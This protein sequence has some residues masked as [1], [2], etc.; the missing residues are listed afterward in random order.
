MRERDIPGVVIGVARGAE[1]PEYLAVGADAAGRSLADDTLFP[2]TSITKLATALAVLR[3]VAAG[4]LALNDPLARHLPE[5]AAAQEGVTLRTI[6][7]HT[8]GLPDDLAPDAAPYTADLNWPALAQA[9]LATSLVESPGT[10]VRYSSVGFGL[11]AIIVERLTGR[12][13]AAALAE[14]VLAPLGVEGYLGDEPPWTPARID[15]SFGAHAG[16]DLEPYNTPFWRSL[17]MPW[18]SMVTNA[19]WSARPCPRLCGAA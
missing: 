3:L 17:A 8:A 18:G 5:A 2:V 14:L 15:G 1:A 4:A 13:F 19:C 10:S 16:T 7:R 6:L 11:L 12:R 9:C